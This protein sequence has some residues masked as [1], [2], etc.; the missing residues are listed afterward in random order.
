M[1]LSQVGDKG[2]NTGDIT[3]FGLSNRKDVR[4]TVGG[5]GL[6]E[7]EKVQG[8]GGLSLRYYLDI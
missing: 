5:S 3:V 1:D 7:V 4:E 6:G 8:L 2:T